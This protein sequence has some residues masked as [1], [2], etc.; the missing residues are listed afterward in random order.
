VS[1]EVEPWSSEG[2]S[3]KGFIIMLGAWQDI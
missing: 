3:A 1:I 2:I